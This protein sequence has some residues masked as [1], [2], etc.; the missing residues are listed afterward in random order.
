MIT[1]D[2]LADFAAALRR[3]AAGDVRTDAITR[4]LYS[5]DASLYQ[6]LPHAVFIP[7]RRPMVNSA[8]DS[9]SAPSAPLRDQ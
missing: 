3:R 8:A 9:I 7:R 6:L 2:K 1:D 5:S 4:A